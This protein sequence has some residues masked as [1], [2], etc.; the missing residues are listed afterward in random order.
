[1]GEEVIKGDRVKSLDKLAP[2]NIDDYKN[3]R[4]K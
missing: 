3:S 4:T 2:L 1:M